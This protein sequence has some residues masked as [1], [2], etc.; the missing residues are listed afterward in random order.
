MSDK[1]VKKSSIQDVVDI[2]KTQAGVSNSITLPQGVVDTISTIE[3]IVNRGSPSVLLNANS[4]NDKTYPIPKGRFTGGA[5]T[6]NPQEKIVT[7][8]TKKQTI[9]AD[10]N[11]TL[12]K[13][14][15]QPTPLYKVQTGTFTLTSGTNAIAK[16]SWSI[17]GLSFKPEG[18]IIGRQ[19]LGF[20]NGYTIVTM[21]NATHG[22][23]GYGVAENDGTASNKAPGCIVNTAI[24]L[25]TNSVSVSAPKV[26]TPDGTIKDA[27]F[28][29]KTYV[30]VIWGK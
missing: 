6:V 20:G 17:T 30:Y 9:T 8:T 29:G 23:S 15:V 5:V 4:E 18:V 3:P 26:T 25:G 27:R 11:R 14:T 7:P 24:S 21:T 12:K 2:A 13:V 16:T 1:I 22:T 10:T 19:K 28:F